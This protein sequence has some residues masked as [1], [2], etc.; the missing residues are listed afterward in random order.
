MNVGC[1][2]QMDMSVNASVV[3]EV[4]LQ[5]LYEVARGVSVTKSHHV[6]HWQALYKVARK[7]FA[8]K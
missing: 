5:V 1:C 3:E 6:L 8:T 4:H 2:V 7:V